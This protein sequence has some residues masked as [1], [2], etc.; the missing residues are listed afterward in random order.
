MTPTLKHYIIQ[1]KSGHFSE[2]EKG[3]RAVLESDS[4]N[5]VALHFLGLLLCQTGRLAE[6]I[7]LIDQSMQLSPGHPEF[8]QNRAMIQLSTGDTESAISNLQRALAV[9]PNL[10]T[11]KLALANAYCEVGRLQEGVILFKELLSQNPAD[12]SARFGAARAL[13]SLG[14]S[15]AALSILKSFDR[16]AICDS[17]AHKLLRAQLLSETGQPSAALEIVDI[18]LRTSPGNRDAMLCRGMALAH[19]RRNIEAASQFEE[20]VF[21][22]NTDAQASANL[23][24]VLHREGLLQRAANAIEQA[25]MVQ[26]ANPD[27]KWISSYIYLSLGRFDEGW[28]A[29]EYRNTQSDRSWPLL[30]TTKPRWNNTRVR[31]RVYIWSEQGIGDEL[32]FG[33]WLSTAETFGNEVIVG[34]DKRLVPLFRRSFPTLNIVSKQPP[35]MEDSY[36]AH[37]PMGSLPKA[38]TDTGRSWRYKR[39]IPY[40]SADSTRKRE[41]VAKLKNSEKL[42]CGVTWKS[43]RSELGPQKSLSLLEM[44]RIFSIPLFKFVNLQYGDVNADIADLSNALGFNPFEPI[45]IDNEIDMDGHAALI[46]ACDVL[47]L[48]CNATAHLAGALGKTGY[49]LT[50]YGKSLIWYWCNQREDRSFWYPSLTLA[51]QD[52]DGTWNEAINQIVTKLIEFDKEVR[53]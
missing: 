26:P 38:L 12:T 34:L 49:V 32:F 25:M 27:F 5:V 50:P 43:F 36:D 19:L 10:K 30:A 39:R 37:L 11:A 47:I 45:D 3:Y 17:H 42:I 4:K 14:Q 7:L 15:S 20:I 9:R 53:Q 51:K 44:R 33:Q 23:A 28:A 41:L 18:I 13:R 8:L 2:A 40:L 31:S 48:C 35:P 16:H 1:H 22:D 24:V 52:M 21:R 29:F 46:D 6:G